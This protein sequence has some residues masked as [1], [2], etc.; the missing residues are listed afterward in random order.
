MSTESHK[1]QSLRH[2]RKS[3]SIA[4]KE[5]RVLFNKHISKIRVKFY[6]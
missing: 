2:A 1:F 4:E 3:V 6:K 5:V